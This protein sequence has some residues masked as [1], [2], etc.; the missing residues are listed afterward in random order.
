MKQLDANLIL[1]VTFHFIV[2][3]IIIYIGLK[4]KE[5]EEDK[6]ISDVWYDGLLF[7]GLIALIYNLKKL[8]VHLFY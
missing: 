3:G 8:G 1:I 2:S 4:G 7:L 6:K 5:K